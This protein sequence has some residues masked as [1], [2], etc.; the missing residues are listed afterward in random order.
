MRQNILESGMMCE[1]FNLIVT[2][3]FLPIIIVYPQVAHLHQSEKLTKC[4]SDD[5]CRGAADPA[6]FQNQCCPHCPFL[7]QQSSLPIKARTQSCPHARPH[8]SDEY[9]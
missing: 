3:D 6:L 9:K 4:T 5:S 8:P 7:F 2:P 1:I